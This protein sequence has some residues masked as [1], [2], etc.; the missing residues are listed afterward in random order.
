MP[1]PWIDVVTSPASSSMG[2][3]GP[4]AS[5]QT[6]GCLRCTRE[7]GGRQVDDQKMRAYAREAHSRFTAFS[8]IFVTED[9]Y[10]SS[11]VHRRMLPMLSLSSRWSRPGCSA[12]QRAVAALIALTLVLAACLPIARPA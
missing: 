10:T 9:R 8:K 12:Y 1:P 2:A 6:S 7:R 4:F 11:T 5:T 3:V